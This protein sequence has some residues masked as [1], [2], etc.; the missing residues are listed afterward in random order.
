[1]FKKE[2]EDTK[3]ID[4]P[5]RAVISLSMKKVI[6]CVLTAKNFILCTPKGKEQQIRKKRRSVSMRGLQ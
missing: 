6:L 1:M 2:T 4:N 3:Y 5:Y